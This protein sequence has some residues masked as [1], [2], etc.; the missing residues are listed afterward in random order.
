MGFIAPPHAE[1]STEML[2]T[3]T[4]EHAQRR[5]SCLLTH[6][7]VETGKAG[8]VIVLQVCRVEGGME[9]GGFLLTTELSVEHNTSVHFLP[10]V[11]LT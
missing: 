3:V 11:P 1:R 7:F 6:L 8:E 2:T 4:R 9:G 10:I 5:E